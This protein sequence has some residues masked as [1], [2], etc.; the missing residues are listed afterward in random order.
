MRKDF[1]HGRKYEM[2]AQLII[3]VIF[4]QYLIISFDLI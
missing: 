3:N 2:P 4:D 1:S